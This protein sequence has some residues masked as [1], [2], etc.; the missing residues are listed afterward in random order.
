MPGSIGST[1]HGLKGQGRL[2]KGGGGEDCDIRGYQNWAL[3]VIR[4]S[5][6]LGGLT[7]RGGGHRIEAIWFWAEKLARSP[8]SEA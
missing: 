3:I 8:Q 7:N 2:F 4:G 1:L 5:Y 6:L